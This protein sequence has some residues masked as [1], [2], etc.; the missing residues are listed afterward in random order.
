M[1]FYSGLAVQ[2]CHGI[3]PCTVNS[4]SANATTYEVKNSEATC[5]L[6]VYQHG[7][8]VARSEELNGTSSLAS[9]LYRLEY[10]NITVGYKMLFYM[11]QKLNV[12]YPVFNCISLYLACN[13]SNHTMQ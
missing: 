1:G 9:K 2:E 13:L 12:K 3:Q 6:L 10:W 11:C 5:T 4:V 7:I 8:V